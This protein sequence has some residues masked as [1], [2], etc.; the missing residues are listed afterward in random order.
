[1]DV[2]EARGV[3]GVTAQDGWDDVRAAYRRIMQQVHPDRAG[4]G[5]A[6][7]AVRVNQA[8][9]TLTRARRARPAARTESSPPS[10]AAAPATAAPAAGSI[11]RLLESARADGMDLVRIGALPQRA[12]SLLLAAGHSVGEVSYVDRASGIIEV[13]V[14]HDGETC[15]LLMML[16]TPPSG[17]EPATHVLVALE[18]LTRAASPSPT[19]VVRSLL[20]ALRP[21]AQ[22]SP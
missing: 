12:F 5:R 9:L 8:Y 14:Q 3:L 20:A 2:D 18:S 17:P 6:Y 21:D 16:E 10:A 7:E 4:A 22:S 15:S 1:M 19:S 13:V 11:G